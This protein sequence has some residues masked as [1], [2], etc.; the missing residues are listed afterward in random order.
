MNEMPKETFFQ[1]SNVLLKW[2]NLCVLL[3][4]TSCRNLSMF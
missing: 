1:T 3:L 4:L 2:V